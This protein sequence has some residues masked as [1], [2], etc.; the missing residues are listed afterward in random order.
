MVRFHFHRD[1]GSPPGSRLFYI[2]AIWSGR[3]ENGG[4]R[5]SRIQFLLVRE[6]GTADYRIREIKEVR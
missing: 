1:R 5:E 3:E 6:E 2:P 4:T